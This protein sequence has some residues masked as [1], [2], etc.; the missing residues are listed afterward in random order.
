MVFIDYS[1][2][3]MTYFNAKLAWEKE[4]KTP[5][6]IS[7]LTGKLLMKNAAA[8]PA[9]GAPTKFPKWM[10]E[11]LQ[12]QATKAGGGRIQHD[13]DNDV[14]KMRVPGSI[15]D[16]DEFFVGMQKAYVEL[17]NDPEIAEFDKNHKLHPSIT[18]HDENVEMADL[19]NHSRGA[20]KKPEEEADDDLEESENE[21]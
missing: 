6:Q 10:R 12:E 19:E 15:L 16:I 13:V 20:T 17:L 5:E 8:R 11:F 18:A 3:D 4:G 9:S 2:T 21:R 1:L 14:F 7:D